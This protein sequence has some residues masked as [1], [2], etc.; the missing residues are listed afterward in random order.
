VNALGNAYSGGRVVTVP[1]V[2]PM[3]DGGV[4]LMGE[5]G[6]EGI[7]PLE[8]RN[9]KLGIRASGGGGDTHVHMT[10]VTKDADSFRK[11]RRQILQDIRRGVR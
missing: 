7:F 2:F 8:R 6:E 5:A 4:G 3:A 11:S 1:T 10:V 9:G